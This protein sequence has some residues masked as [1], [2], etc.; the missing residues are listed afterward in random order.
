MMQRQAQTCTMAIWFFLLFAFA[1]LI[2]A[3]PAGASEFALVVNDVSGLTA[4]W[5]LMASLP[6]PEGEITN[7]S[8][9]RIV[10]QGKEVP[11]QIDV[12][13]TWRDGSIRWALA[14]FTASP[15]ADYW[16]EYGPGVKRAPHP[17]PLKMNREADGSLLVD[18]GAAAY[19]FAAD[20]LL[21][22]RAWL[23]TGHDRTPILV[24]SGD[25]TYLVDN[26]GRT[27]RVAG[28]TADVATEVLREGPGR[29]VL[30][31]SGW[32]VTPTGE[33]LA[34]AEAWFYLAAGSAFMRVTHSLI[35]TQDT[36]KVWVR[37]YGLQF[38]TPAAP[39]RVACTR[40]EVGKEDLK[41]VA[42]DG[43]EVFLL[44]DT[45]P[46]FAERESRAVI[47][48]ASGKDERILEEFPCAGDWAH[49]DYGGYGLTVVMPW[50]AERFP[51]E[52]A[53]GPQGARAVLWSGRSGRE[54]D[55]RGKTL[56][57]EYWQ[58]WARKGPGSPGADALANWPSNA[59][60]V[61][62][63]HDIWL[64]PHT[65]GYDADVVRTTAIAAARPPLALAD[66]K[67]LCA[68]KAMGYPMLHKDVERFPREE[69]LISEYWDRFVL[70]LRA[71]PTHGFIA[72]GQFPVWYYAS[73][74]GRIMA[75]FHILTHSDPYGFRREP[76]RLYA[77][78]GER[79]Y[80]DYAHRFTRHTGDFY[81]A[82]CDAPGPGKERGAF[83][84]PGNK[85]RH[86]PFLWGDRTNRF[87]IL[88]GDI[89][90]WL[91]DYYLTGD[92]RSLE[93]VHIVR[94]S[95]RKH[96]RVGSTTPSYPIK[97]L[98]TLVTLSILDW[99]ED[100]NLMARELA[101]S[102][103]DLESQ[104]GVRDYGGYGPM[105]KDSRNAHNFVEYYMET[106]DEI[107][108]EAF[109][110]LV[111]QRYRFDRRVNPIGY[112][113]YDG[114]THSLAYWMTGDQRYRGAAEQAVRDSLLAVAGH[115]LFAELARLPQ[116]PLDWKRMPQNLSIAFYQ[117]P[118]VG[119]PTALR[120]IADEGWS[121][122]T[123]P[124]VVKPMR[125]P[126][127]K[128]LFEHKKGGDTRLSIYFR[129]QRRNIQLAVL[130]Y[131][132]RAAAS[133]VRGIAVEMQ[134]RMPLGPRY[135]ADQH[136]HYHAFLTVPPETPDGLYLLSVDGD[137][138]FTVL[139]A[140]RSKV[141]LYCPEGFWSVSIGEHSGS[142]S[143]GRPG[144]GMPA[145]FRVPEHVRNLELLLGGPA[146]VRA[147]DGS[148]AVVMSDDNIG[149]LSI[150]VEG[151]AGI[152]SIEPYIHT[153]AGDC[154]PSFF[155]LLNVEPVVAFGAA[156][157]LPQ[158]VRGERGPLAPPPPEPRAESEFVGGIAGRAVKLAGDHTLRFPRGES[159]T[160]GGYAHFPGAS[161]TAEFWFRPD[162][163][164]HETPI[165]VYGQA[166]RSLLRGPH[167]VLSHRWYRK[168]RRVIHS[169]LR[170]ELRAAKSGTPPAGLECRH[171]FRAGQWVHVAYTW[172]IRQGP[173][174]MEGSLAVLIDGRRLSPKRVPYGLKE[175]AG[176]ARFQLSEQ[177]DEIVLG[178]FQGTMDSLRLSDIVRYP[179][180][181]VPT[182]R[183]PQ[184]DRHTRAVFLFDGD[185]EGTSAFSQTPIQAHQY[186]RGAQ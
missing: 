185:L 159:L 90:S 80:Y 150:P 154:P 69:A 4:P 147:P 53:F 168:P 77:R 161:G 6:F 34:R 51:K 166:E 143:Y 28:A 146:W 101:R 96:W 179:G 25:G 180:D 140:T 27:A 130:P 104:N 116:N 126:S 8:A 65:G 178:P 43:G 82:H 24:G 138:T 35:F 91:M 30:K 13:A 5:P 46:H 102:L 73:V 184:M 85:G 84:F 108:K 11:A 55:F 29:V 149:R 157:H 59:Q 144:E 63:T 105:Y 58:T 141:A 66:P 113:N 107:A 68:T 32:Y 60:G 133:P 137:E 127:A 79:R 42:A 19:E 87:Y 183:P 128:A 111:D 136:Q 76:W 106:G 78:S 40:G 37:D 158:A 164:T 9:I 64:V 41:T 177:G 156:S 47:G 75:R 134:E 95:F 122:E 129:S 74:D 89:G 61:A 151:R 124:L 131:P 114:F 152:W 83:A 71:F 135:P 163:S 181:F 23:G 175:L 36:N 54:L 81:L 62:R 26:Q 174:R 18:T 94:D 45:Y 52:I 92:E 186:T 67:W 97:V 118:F 17:A 100:L 70:P 153:F 14:G 176:R 103:I 182:R 155:R 21:P 12:A 115:P 148:V 93:L 165:R 132:E 110:K 120:L 22:E 38:R 125:V 121:G 10:S 39:Q 173:K 44:Q 57:A 56:V 86:L 7:A 170:L 31:R 99:D 142:A 117:H 139:D 119:L 172:Q 16:V 20:K 145:Y 112:K 171:F 50:L 123:T 162:W 33:Q 48:R 109:L 88:S 72:W 15:G 169:L 49:G 167:L 160:E 98:R 2:L 1:F 3:P